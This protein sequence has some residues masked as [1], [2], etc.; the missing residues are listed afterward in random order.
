L[1]RSPAEALLNSHYVEYIMAEF[2]VSP[3]VVYTYL[4]KM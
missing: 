3:T 4:G 1:K 2:K